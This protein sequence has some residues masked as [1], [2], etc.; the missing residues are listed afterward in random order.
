MMTVTFGFVGTCR[1]LAPKAT[2]L[3]C[4]TLLL[5]GYI[6]MMLVAPSGV[7]FA[8][9]YFR[10]KRYA[11]PIGMI[12]L[13]AS[14]YSAYA[15]SYLF[16]LYDLLEPYHFDPKQFVFWFG[17]VAYFPIVILFILLPWLFTNERLTK[18]TMFQETAD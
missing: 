1:L 11:L 13:T 16:F 10:R 9:L 7:L 12:S 5:T 2:D 14:L 8:V 18:T 4:Q 3:Q 17:T 6:D 15:F